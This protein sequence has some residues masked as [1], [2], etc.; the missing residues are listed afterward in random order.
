MSC[1]SGS[2]DS[3]K[4]DLTEVLLRDA[5]KSARAIREGSDA[6]NRQHS[7]LSEDEI[8]NV[9]ELFTFKSTK[10]KIKQRYFFYPSKQSTKKSL[11]SMYDSHPP[12][13]FGTAAALAEIQAYQD[14][15]EL[16]SLD[17]FAIPGMLKNLTEC[18]L[19]VVSHYT[20]ERSDNSNGCKPQFYWMA[21]GI[22]AFKK[23]VAHVNTQWYLENQLLL[24]M[25]LLA[26]N[27]VD[28]GCS[29]SGEEL[30]SLEKLCRAIEIDP[31]IAAAALSQGPIVPNWPERNRVKS[32]F[33]TVDSE[34][35]SNGLSRKKRL[36]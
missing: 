14:A 24:V 34:E 35:V 27:C 2:I 17:S 3:R 12:I 33:S 23:G 32:A 25:H 6:I 29:R 30:Y 20:A 19:S 8:G 5:R 13:H 16:G 7:G 15:A 26:S 22:D 4:R 10:Q 11:L 28:W 1:Y 31:N 18:D 21:R 9:V 36:K